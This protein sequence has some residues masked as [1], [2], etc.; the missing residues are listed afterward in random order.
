MPHRAR[1]VSIHQG[2]HGSSH[3][4]TPLALLTRLPSHS[5]PPPHGPHRSAGELS[6]PRGR[7]GRPQAVA[8]VA[9]PPS[10]RR[11][12]DYSPVTGTEKA[13]CWSV[14]GVAQALRTLLVCRVTDDDTESPHSARRVAAPPPGRPRRQ[15]HHLAPSGRR[16]TGSTSCSRRPAIPLQTMPYP[17]A[18]EHIL[19]R[20]NVGCGAG[21]SGVCP[22]RWRTGE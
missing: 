22:W 18:H 4:G 2:M 16:P 17:N 3:G 9:V 19:A 5:P 20:N 8:C 14:R 1:A 6:G 13:V 21:Q 11:S 12:A 10:V 15:R 7:F